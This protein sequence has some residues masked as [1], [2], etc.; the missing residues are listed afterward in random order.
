MTV[1][2]GERVEGINKIAV[3][4]STREHAMPIMI[5]IVLLG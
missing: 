4:I 3:M 2:V 1:N 5:P